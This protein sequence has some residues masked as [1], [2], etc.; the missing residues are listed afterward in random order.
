MIAPRQNL[1]W[2]H[3]PPS[4]RSCP[5]PQRSISPA[6]PTAP[7]NP[8]AFLSADVPCY[9]PIQT[10]DP[11]GRATI[12]MAFGQQDAE[13][14]PAPSGF[15]TMSRTRTNRLQ[16]LNRYRQ[17]AVSTAWEFTAKISWSTPQ[18]KP[19]VWLKTSCQS[20]ASDCRVPSA[21]ACAGG[22]EA[23]HPQAQ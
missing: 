10:A 5:Q 13:G 14:F 17:N 3:R 18:W 9:T 1:L 7:T 23:D 2:L 11:P 19:P 22:P 21:P 20:S 6:S 15:T 12:L 16:A 8:R 4:G